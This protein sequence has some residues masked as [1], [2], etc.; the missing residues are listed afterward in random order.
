MTPRPS[1][2][3]PFGLPSSIAAL[4]LLL[5]VAGTST[6]NSLP[7]ESAMLPLEL[8]RHFPELA[9]LGLQEPPESPATLRTPLRPTPPPRLAEADSGRYLQGLPFGREIERAARAH[10]LDGLLIASV[11]EAESSFRPDAVSAKGALGL[12]QLMP[13]HL[14]G[15]AEPLDPAVNLGIGTRY[16][17]RLERRFEGDLELALAAYHAGPGAVERWGGVPPYRSTRDYVGRVLARYAEHRT[18]AG[19]AGAG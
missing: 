7:V 16:L 8:A 3:R 15:I 6:S 9:E 5:G 18:I 19:R 17:A 11:V 13:L 4:T 1:H 10:R 14:E 2:R 12:M